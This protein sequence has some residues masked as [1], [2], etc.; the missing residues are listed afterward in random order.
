MSESNNAHAYTVCFLFAKD[1]NHVL[2]Q[3]KDK[4]EFAGLWNGVGG[5]CRDNE[6]PEQCAYREIQ[7]ETGVKPEEIQNLTHLGTLT[8]PYDCKLEQKSDCILHYF[9]GTVDRDKPQPQPGE[10]ELL[11]WHNTNYVRNMSIT[12]AEKYFAGNGDLQFFVH[13]GVKA[14]L[15]K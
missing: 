14:L 8:L 2:L 11:E 1:M 15:N 6:T 3:R 9:A 4:T 10:P 7:E 12:S 5:S 13:L